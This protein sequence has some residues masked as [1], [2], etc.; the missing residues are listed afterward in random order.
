MNGR[1]RTH[2]SMP[3]EP[4]PEP[5]EGLRF[6]Q[7]VDILKWYAAGTKRKLGLAA[8]RIHADRDVLPGGTPILGM[9]EALEVMH[10]LNFFEVDRDR[11][12]E[13]DA[14]ERQSKDY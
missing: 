14:R 11:D 4:R 5:G 8:C 1:I 7:K 9:Q 2:R 13:P 10:Y 6:D 3:E 12:R